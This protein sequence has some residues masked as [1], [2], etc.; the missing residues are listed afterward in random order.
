MQEDK[1]KMKGLVFKLDK[2]GKSRIFKLNK[3]KEQFKARLELS[4]SNGKFKLDFSIYKN[5]EQA[6]TDLFSSVFSISKKKS[7]TVNTNVN[8]F[9]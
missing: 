5:T 4:S 6:R 7:D 2:K 9:F 3:I 8:N 1:E